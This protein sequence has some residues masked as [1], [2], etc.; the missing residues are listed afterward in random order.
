[1]SRYGRSIDPLRGSGVSRSLAAPGVAP[2]PVIPDQTANQV[3]GI[4]G[5]SLRATSAVVDF[6]AGAERIRIG[7]EREAAFRNQ[8]AMLQAERE[9][10]DTLKMQEG[11]GADLANSLARTIQQRVASGEFGTPESDDP[12]DI[13][14][15]QDSVSSVIAAQAGADATPMT[16]EA[17]RRASSRNIVDA[18]VARRAEVIAEDTAET[19]RA[20]VSGSLAEGGPGQS[21]LRSTAEKL[22]LSES[23]AH[24]RLYYPAAR[25]AASQ[26][27]DA[28]AK[29]ADLFKDQKYSAERIE[30]ESVARRVDDERFRQLGAS[31]DRFAVL[32][33]RAQQKAWEGFQDRFSADLANATRLD[34][35]NT[36][37]DLRGIEKYLGDAVEK[38]PGWASRL[39][40]PLTATR[41]RIGNYVDLVQVQDAQ[42]SVIR[43]QQ[44]YNDDATLAYL[45]GNGYAVGM[46]G[47]EF[48]ASTPD[49]RVVAVKQSAN[50]TRDAAMNGAVA[51]IISEELS[52]VAQDPSLS[53]PQQQQQ[54]YM[55]ALPRL[56]AQVFAG[57]QNKYQPIESLLQAGAN[58]DAAAFTEGGGVPTRSLEAVQHYLA[59]ERG[60]PDV[61]KKYAGDNTDFYES[62]KYLMQQPGIGGDPAKAIQE[63]LRIRASN[64]RVPELQAR[65]LQSSITSGIPDIDGENYFLVAPSVSKRRDHFIRSGMAP[66]LALTRA[67]EVEKSRV[68]VVNGMPIMAGAR[69]LP[70]GPYNDFKKS[71]EAAI[72]YLR[73]RNPEVRSGTD[74]V[75]W[76]KVFLSMD[77]TSG[78]TVLV[79][80]L[81]LPVDLP[82]GD[83]IN[84]LDDVTLLAIRAKRD[85]IIA[86]TK[87]SKLTPMQQAYYDG[88]GIDRQAIKNAPSP[89]RLLGDAAVGT[90][91]AAVDFGRW[92]DTRVAIPS[93][94]QQGSGNYVNRNP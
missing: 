32:E 18:Y 62:I 93:R 77:Q 28:Y 13:L 67:I 48:A 86:A 26:G 4:V 68:A 14:S 75:N 61:A 85:G 89:L 25:I 83:Q 6:M 29:F 72:D 57:A 16:Y 1:M 20:A 66:S 51:T 37:S 35:A 64:I 36:L 43:Q 11:L 33:E 39:L 94:G 69:I 7:Q 60:S 65:D 91:N 10:Q 40:A 19:Y 23:D 55:A 45:S 12:Q 5:E 41:E 58:V 87:P 59:L 54:A 15:W 52:R 49:G 79:S 34:N 92:W 17:F 80:E 47:A 82:P 3:A 46:D 90:T 53:T 84:T 42:Q 8:Q 78:K 2:I 73:Q 30:L 31:A 63:H 27:S 70:P 44:V 88:K 9:N 81:G 74:P 50:E 38:N 24:S 21:L 22:G 76:D 71:A 56:A